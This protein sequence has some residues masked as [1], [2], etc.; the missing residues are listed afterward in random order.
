M[1]SQRQTWMC[2][3]SPDGA[4]G[5]NAAGRT[6]LGP[7][8]GAWLSAPCLQVCC[9]ST[10]RRED[11]RHCAWASCY[12]LLGSQSATWFHSWLQE[13]KRRELCPFHCPPA[14]RHLHTC[15]N[16]LLPLELPCGGSEASEEG[17]NL[18]LWFRI[19]RC[20]ML[21]WLVHKIVVLRPWGKQRGKLF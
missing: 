20:T 21:I 2:W 5:R 14:A 17:R 12:R 9:R 7:S 8:T 3:I 11:S 10:E 4:D 16:T 18:Q 19:M 1:Y 13:K 15:R 6:P